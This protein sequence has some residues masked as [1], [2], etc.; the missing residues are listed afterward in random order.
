ME[1]N[2]EQPQEEEKKEEEKPEFEK[3]LEEMRAENQRMEKNIQEL[4]ELKAIDALG[5][6]TDSLQPEKPKEETFKDYKDKVM[7]GEIKLQ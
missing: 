5:G 4:K 1:E 2:Q 6:K 3:K 7:K